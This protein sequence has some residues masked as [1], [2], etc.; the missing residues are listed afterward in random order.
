MFPTTGSRAPSGADRLASMQESDQRQ[1]MLDQQQNQNFMEQLKTLYGMGQSSQLMPANLAHMNAE[2]GYLGAQTQHLGQEDQQTAAMQPYLQQHMQGEEERANQ[3]L[4]ATLAHLGADTSHLTSED[5]RSAA[6]LP[7]Q[8]QNLQASTGSSNAT[9][10]HMT[11]EEQRG[12]LMFP[13]QQ[14]KMQ[15]ETDRDNAIT[16]AAG[17]KSL[18]HIQGIAALEQMGI[19]PH[20]TAENL[21]RIAMPEMGQFMDQAHAHDL[22]VKQAQLEQQATTGGGI[23][24]AMEPQIA[25]EQGPDFLAHLKTLGNQSMPPGMSFTPEQQQIPQVQ[26]ELQDWR[27]HNP[28]QAPGQTPDTTALI[29]QLHQMNHPWASALRSFFNPASYINSVRQAIV[30]PTQ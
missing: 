17:P 22:Q 8:Q 18:A 16:Q 30:Q 26:T 23:P 25:A 15:A 13:K 3:L 9:T 7:Y 14:A 28:P 1:Q 29:D 10:A 12:S 27:S 11:G 20:G 21:A 5:A 24:P 2:V 6:M 4:P 19:F